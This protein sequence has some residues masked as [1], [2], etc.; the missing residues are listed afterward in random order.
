M[1][2]QPWLVESLSWIG[3]SQLPW[4]RICDG[5]ENG[6]VLLLEIDHFRIRFVDIVLVACDNDL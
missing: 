1:K 4:L 3:A 2:L 5:Q 6:Q